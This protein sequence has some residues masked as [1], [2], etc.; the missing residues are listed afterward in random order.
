MSTTL[1][2]SPRSAS[3][4]S[5]PDE[6]DKAAPQSSSRVCN[7]FRSRLLQLLLVLTVGAVLIGLGHAH[8]ISHLASPAALGAIGGATGAFILGTLILSKKRVKFE[9]GHSFKRVLWSLESDPKKGWCSKITDNLSISGLPSTSDD[10]S[11]FGLVINCCEKWEGE[12]TDITGRIFQT[13]PSLGIPDYGDVSHSILDEQA[14]AI[15]KAISEG[16]K[17]LVHCKSGEGRSAQIIAAYLMKYQNKSATEAI[18]FVQS[19]R[20][21]ALQLPNQIA[22]LNA[23]NPGDNNGRSSV[24]LTQSP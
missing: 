20:T 15:H 9:A 6:Y 21:R 23:Y 14:D 10:L 16:K 13:T 8:I 5:F 4:N 24:T 17:V 1:L 3:V 19:Q 12:A 2:L 7:L 11:E 22:N 18:A